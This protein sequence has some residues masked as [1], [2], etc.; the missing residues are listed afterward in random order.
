[1]KESFEGGMPLKSQLFHL[2]LALLSFSLQ[3]ALFRLPFLLKHLSVKFQIEEEICVKLVFGEQKLQHF[4]L[5]LFRHTDFVD[6]HNWQ[7]CQSAS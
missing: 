6:K 3:V 5:E 2:P 1:M 4:S 7:S